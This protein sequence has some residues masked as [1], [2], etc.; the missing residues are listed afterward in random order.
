MKI[1]KQ[2]RQLEISKIMKNQLNRPVLRRFLA[3]KFGVSVKTV[4]RDCN[5]LKKAGHTFRGTAGGIVLCKAPKRPL[6]EA[7][8][9]PDAIA[10]LGGSVLEKALSNRS[11]VLLQ[12][13][14]ATR[15]YLACPLMVLSGYTRSGEGAILV[16]ET[17]FK[18]GSRPVLL[19]HLSKLEIQ[20][21]NDAAP[22]T[23]RRAN[24]P[25]LLS[26]CVSSYFKGEGLND[27]ELW[28]AC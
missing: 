28:F 22:L 8:L 25:N 16:A 4:Q 23:A 2:Q 21:W 1:N 20:P 6:V 14:S 13:K 5:E 10:E 18:D 24:L 17:Q 19:F 15:N 26:K 3:E 11:W 27:S 9:G 7:W 12:L